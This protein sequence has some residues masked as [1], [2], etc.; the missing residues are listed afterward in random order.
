MSQLP[1]TGRLFVPDPDADV[2]HILACPA[3]CCWLCDPHHVQL[4]GP[5]LGPVLG[6]GL[7]Q[8]RHAKDSTLLGD[9]ANNSVPNWHSMLA[10]S[11]VK[12]C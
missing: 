4:I 5:L 11:P 12:G 9:S 7:A 3:V 8:V 1:L 10:A 6:G 2:F